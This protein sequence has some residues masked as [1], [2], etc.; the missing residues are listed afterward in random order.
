MH[1]PLVVEQREQNMQDWSWSWFSFQLHAE[2]SSVWFSRK[3]RSVLRPREHF[4]ERLQTNTVAFCRVTNFSPVLFVFSC[5]YFNP[6]VYS[7][8]LSETL[9]TLQATHPH[10]PAPP[11]GGNIFVF[12]LL[13]RA[14][15][16]TEP[17]CRGGLSSRLLLILPDDR[18]RFSDMCCDLP[19]PGAICCLT[20][21]RSWCCEIECS[22]WAFSR[23][24]KT[25]AVSS[26]WREPVPT[27]LSAPSLSRPLS[28]YFIF[29]AF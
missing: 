12:V 9:P 17:R 10:T 19:R 6:L 26:E 13:G 3:H 27:W 18:Q 7:P 20:S 14:A 2:L 4:T 21:A 22:G 8:L 15:R 11:P 5:T 16:S 29:Q 28:F 25:S 23:R 1:F 24:F